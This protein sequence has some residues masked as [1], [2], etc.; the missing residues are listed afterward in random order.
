MP[1]RRIWLILRAMLAPPFRP[2]DSGAGASPGAG[3]G[4]GI[5]GQTPRRGSRLCRWPR[6]IQQKGQISFSN[7][8][9]PRES[10]QDCASCT[11]LSS[12]SAPALSLSASRIS[13]RRPSIWCCASF[14]AF[15]AYGANWTSRFPGI[16]NNIAYSHQQKSAVEGCRSVC[17]THVQWPTR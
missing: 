8:S 9:C 12:A 10:T 13:F 7:N 5:R 11:G 16:S 6:F 4:A 17:P 3:D 1:V 15:F 14:R 2:L